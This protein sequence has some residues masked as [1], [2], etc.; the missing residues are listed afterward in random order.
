MFRV[1]LCGFLVFSALQVTLPT[2]IYAI[3]LDDD[4]EDAEDVADLLAEVKKA[5]K[6]ESFDKAGELLKKAKMYGISKDDI[7]EA[8]NYVAKKKQAKA[9][10]LERERKE[11]ERLARLKREREER[12]RRA[13]LA[14]QRSYGGSYSRGGSVS[15]CVPATP[16]PVSY[17]QCTISSGGFYATVKLSRGGGMSS[18]NCFDLNIYHSG[19]IGVANTCGGVNGSWSYNVNGSS[20][21]ANGIGQT[22]SQMVQRMR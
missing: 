11:R 12:A 8:S 7:A 18:A 19:S 9:D 21:F 15:I 20:G 4:E 14:A 16:S 1:I 10:R 22:I 3:S 17:S 6:S 5:A 13:R 2:N